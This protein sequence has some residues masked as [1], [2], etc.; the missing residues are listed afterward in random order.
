MPRLPRVTALKLIRVLK[1][2]GFVEHPER[3][4]SHLVFSHS[5]GRRTVVARHGGRDIK[6]GTLAGILRDIKISQESFR[7]LL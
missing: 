2:C 3:G 1:K 5:D 7:K 6:K 4:T